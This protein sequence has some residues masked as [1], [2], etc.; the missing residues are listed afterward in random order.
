MSAISTQTEIHRWLKFFVKW[1][2]PDPENMDEIYNQADDIGNK[3]QKL[4]EEDGIIVKKRAHAGSFGTITGLKRFMLGHSVIEGQDIDIAFIVEPNDKKGNPLG[5]LVDKFKGY[6]EQ[7]YPKSEVGS[8]KSSATINFSGSKRRFDLVPLFVTSTKDIQLL[9]RTNGEERRTSVIKHADFIKERTKQSNEI[10]GVV[11]FNECIRLVKWFRYEQ[12]EKSGVFGNES[13]E[14]KVPSFL[15]NLLCAA[16][17]D[18]RSVDNTYPE[19]LAMWFGYLA[20]VV[21]NRKTVAFSSTYKENTSDGVLWRVI[22]P[23]DDN[24]NLVAKWNGAQ[25]NELA[26]WFEKAR[27]T[28]NRAIRYDEEGDE[29]SCLDSLSTIFGNSFKNNHE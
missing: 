24:N 25:I 6:A 2:S 17:Y 19:T 14:Y 28:I 4:A 11:K 22:D 18:N 5:C 29:I 7:A 8:T 20:N 16:A 27:D 26:T 3:I 23:M 1:I 13:G 12:Q 10:D 15:L 21:R 9:K